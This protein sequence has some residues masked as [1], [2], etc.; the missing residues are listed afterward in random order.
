MVVQI[1]QFEIP[2][3]NGGHVFHN[4]VEDCQE[5]LV[6]CSEAHVADGGGV[7]PRVQALARAHVPQ[8]AAVVRRASEQ[9]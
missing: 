6:A 1:V 5:L 9:Q 7:H 3:E 2:Y 8:L 4:V